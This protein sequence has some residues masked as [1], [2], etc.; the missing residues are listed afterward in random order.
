[1]KNENKKETKP[2]PER[3]RRP[4]NDLLKRTAGEV[5]SYRVR[6][7][8]LSIL[9]SLLVVFAGLIYLVSALYNQSGSFTV[10]VDKYE[11]QKYGLSLSE[12]RDMLTP[13][14][15]LNAKISE[16][17]TNISGDTIDENVDMIDGEHN[18]RHYIAYTFYL[19]NAG[20]TEVS[21]DYEVNM[22][23]VSNSLDEAIRLRLYVDGVPTT[24]A[25]TK[26]D[27]TGPEPD[28]V[29]F[30]SAYTMAKGRVDAFAPDEITKFTVVLWIEGND[31]DCV[32]WL[33]GGQLKVD[34][35][36]SIVH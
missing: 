19:Q 26:S 22:S 34:M 33:I 35:V 32:D 12:S 29:E 1:M 11:M 8:M 17:V 25:K 21:Y 13:T 23:G 5:K 7:K 20:E 36:M 31:P 2:I 28:T 24:Y 10:A 16:S 27:G 4:T 14:S 9:L 18:G 15:N 30:Y 3:R 6:M